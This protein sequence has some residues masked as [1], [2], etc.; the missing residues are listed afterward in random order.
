MEFEKEIIE[1][2]DPDKIYI[3]P[4]IRYNAILVFCSIKLL[5]KEL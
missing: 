3:P 4:L 1:E 5:K 2:V